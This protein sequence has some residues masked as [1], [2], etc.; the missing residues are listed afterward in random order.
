[1]NDMPRNEDILQ[2][3]PDILRQIT[4]YMAEV[5]WVCEP[6]H[7]G[8][9]LY[10]S[11]AFERIWGVSR[12]AL[13]DDPE[14]WF[15]SIHPE[16]QA[17][18]GA[19][20]RSQRCQGRFSGE[21]RILRSDGTMRWIS[22]RVFAVLDGEGAPRRVIGLVE[23]ITAR[24]KAEEEIRESREQLRELVLRQQ[25]DREVLRT[26]IAREIHD[27]LGQSLMALNLNAYW[28]LHQ[29]PAEQQ[30][31]TAKV[32]EMIDVIV[33]TVQAVQRISSELRPSMLDELGLEATMRWYVEQF[34]ARTGIA[35]R[36]DVDLSM[37]TIDDDHATAAY[38]ILQEALTNVSRHSDADEIG[39]K[40]FV[41]DDCLH[42]EIYDNGRGMD[43]HG[44]AMSRSFGLLGM[45]ERAVALG[46]SLEIDSAPGKGTRLYLKLPLGETQ[47]DC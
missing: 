20:F 31:L 30:H 14:L 43:R 42:M 10:V 44:I 11:P 18:I 15:A 4:A 45:Q 7:T 17:R 40:A 33:E 47:G 34:H 16:D 38:R 1:M 36:L 12:Q 21:Y 23:D 41:R 2:V 3:T 32:Q 26:R 22:D 37:R 29:L 6:D 46:G 27:E 35:C 9:L 24:K 8:K 19:A 13:Y 39:L 5:F 28:L 25:W